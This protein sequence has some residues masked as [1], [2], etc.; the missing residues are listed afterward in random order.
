MWRTK[1]SAMLQP[2]FTDR[3]LTSTRGHEWPLTSPFNTSIVTK[4]C[5]L[6]CY[7]GFYRHLSNLTCDFARAAISLQR[8]A[9]W[10]AIHDCART[11][12]EFL[13]FGCINKLTVHINP[14][15]ANRKQ[16]NTA[17]GI[18]GDAIPSRATMSG[19]GRKANWST[20]ARHF[21]W[22]GCSC[23]SFVIKRNQPKPLNL[24]SFNLSG[25]FPSLGIHLTWKWYFTFRQL[26]QLLFP[27]AF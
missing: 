15:P 19:R 2:V 20:S 24:T 4:M 14:S 12:R 18:N 9:H 27:Q 1:V 5:S 22:Q 23:F 16:P 21:S 17:T 6:K 7:L 10:R 13:H 26:K 8:Q 11:R 3:E 25:Y